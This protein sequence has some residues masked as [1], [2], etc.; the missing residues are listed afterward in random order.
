ME[1]TSSDEVGVLVESFNEML[2]QIIERDIALSG[3]KDKA[4]FSAISAKRY[5]K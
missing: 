5:A 2:D 4:E 1:K 3:D